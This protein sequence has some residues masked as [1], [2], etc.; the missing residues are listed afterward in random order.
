MNPYELLDLLINMLKQI[1]E[2]ENLE[3]DLSKLGFLYR[4]RRMMEQVSV[5]DYGNYYGSTGL[6]FF[7]RNS[8]VV[9]RGAAN[10]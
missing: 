8:E 5:A 2:N 9:T 4:P 10:A 1:E 7:W 3:F 6:A